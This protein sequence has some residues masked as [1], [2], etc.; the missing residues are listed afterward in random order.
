MLPDACTS[1]LAL[2]ESG[3]LTIQIP[4]EPD[5]NFDEWKQSI[6]LNLMEKP[7]LTDQT[8]SGNQVE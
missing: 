4:G 5:V 2:E 6:P 7:G 8:I 1:A 3:S